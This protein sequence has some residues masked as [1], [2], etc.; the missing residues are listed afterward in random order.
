MNHRSQIRKTTTEQAAIAF[1]QIHL[2]LTLSDGGV[3]LRLYLVFNLN[4][5][6]IPDF[7]KFFFS[8]LFSEK[9]IGKSSCHV[10][11]SL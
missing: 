6:H 1:G 4:H 8:F 7:L 9:N 5:F 10:T 2:L 11:T 3:V